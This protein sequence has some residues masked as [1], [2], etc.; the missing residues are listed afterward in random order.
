MISK[1]R[2]TNI[3]ALIGYYSERQKMIL[4]YEYI[5]Q[6]TLAI[7]SIE[8]KSL[9]HKTDLLRFTRESFSNNTLTQEANL[10][11]FH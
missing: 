2:H 7:I 10:H 4:V 6:G 9:F 3:V 8:S 5:A 11:Q 1:L